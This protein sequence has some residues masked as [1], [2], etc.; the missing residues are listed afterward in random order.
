[1]ICKAEEGVESQGEGARK[2][3]GREHIM[4]TMISL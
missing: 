1:M 2:E 3:L 4:V